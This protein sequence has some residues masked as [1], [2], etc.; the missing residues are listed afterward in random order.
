MR[1]EDEVVEI[2]A[3]RVIAGVPDDHARRDR[4]SKLFPYV[5]ADQ[6]GSPFDLDN[7]ISIPIGGV[8]NAEVAAGWIDG[9]RNSAEWV[10]AISRH[11][12]PSW[13]KLYSRNPNGQQPGIPSR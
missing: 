4:T 3:G 7:G 10:D 12:L 6:H 13:V 9:I 11:E 1:T 2:D 5:P 8:G